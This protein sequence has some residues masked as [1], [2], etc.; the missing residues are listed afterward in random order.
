LEA[1]AIS[2]DYVTQMPE[3]DAPL[4]VYVD[5]VLD[6]LPAMNVRRAPMRMTAGPLLPNQQFTWSPED[7]IAK[8]PKRGSPV[9]K[10]P[11]PAGILAD[12]TPVGDGAMLTSQGLRP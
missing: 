8:H 9:F 2:V 3:L 4:V 5:P 10:Q 1:F 12:G 6:A 7:M 11:V